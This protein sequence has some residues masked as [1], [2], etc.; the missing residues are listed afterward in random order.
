MLRGLGNPEKGVVHGFNKGA[1]FRNSIRMHMAGL[2]QVLMR[3]RS[4]VLCASIHTRA[5]FNCGTAGACFC[6]TSA[7]LC[8]CIADIE[9]RSEK[10]DVSYSRLMPTSG[11]L[12]TL[13]SEN[14]VLSTLP[15]EGLRGN[16]NACNSLIICGLDDDMPS[17]IL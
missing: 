15:S 17:Y 1:L 9:W 16:S 7:N 3:R 12:G 13:P 2:G 4:V 8:T 14:I 11:P 10:E 5:C 6:C